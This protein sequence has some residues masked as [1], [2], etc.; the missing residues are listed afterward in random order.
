[1]LPW[2]VMGTANGRY[3]RYHS[4]RKKTGQATINGILGIF[5]LSTSALKSI[6]APAEEAQSHNYQH[7]LIL[8]KPVQ[9]SGI[10]PAGQSAYPQS[11]VQIKYEHGDPTPNEQYLLELVN[12]ARS[13]PS[14]EA[15]Q[16]GID[17][18]QGLDPNTISSDSKRP[19]AFNS[20]LIESA[21]FHS[22]NMLDFD[23]FA[24][25]GLDGSVPGDRMKQAGYNFSG[26]WTWGENIG[27]SG[28]TGP[29][30]AT[31][32]VAEIHKG[33]FLSPF[34]RE[35]IM[36]PVFEEIGISTLEGDY[37]YEDK[38][39]HSVMVTQNFAT[40]DGSPRPFLTGVVFLDK[41]NDGFYSVGEGIGGI[42][43]RPTMGSYF[44][45]T[46]ASGGYTLP[47]AK[48]SGSFSVVYSGPGLTSPITKR[49]QAEGGN[50]K[51]DIDLAQGIVSDDMFHFDLKTIRYQSYGAITCDL[52]GSIGLQFTLEFSPNGINW[53]STITNTFASDRFSVQ[54]PVA[55]NNRIGLFRA[56]L[57]K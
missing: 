13:K 29:I 47:L 45:V 19:L 3:M 11:V 40:S 52:Y 9:H 48:Y 25:E 51:L 23:F 41:D 15:S 53:T 6:A 57:V 18:N 55:A 14:E 49:L 34:H 10:S 42:E 5:V 30:N 2:I 7:V 38:D 43:I 50:I 56:R 36:N 39:Y 27:W 54:L 28:S 16:F 4:S 46:T 37:F 33:L 17:L 20:R 31:K 1:M 26:S 32:K 8:G 35:N 22:Q 44:A 21:R 12:R 24:H